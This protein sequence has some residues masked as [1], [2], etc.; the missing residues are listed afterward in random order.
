MALEAAGIPVAFRDV[1]AA[2]PTRAE[3]EAWLGAFGEALVN[4][5]STT[6][7]ALDGAAREDAPVELLLAHPT[8][9]KRPVLIRG[10]RRHLGWDGTALAA[11]GL[12]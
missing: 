3:I 7:R 8:L 11:L 1:R 10:D 6:W 4:R 2:P 12:A 9:M 5:R